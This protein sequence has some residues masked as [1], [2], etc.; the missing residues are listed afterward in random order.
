L[1]SKPKDLQTV[2]NPIRES[3]VNA[4]I[5]RPRMQ[6][7]SVEHGRGQG[8]LCHYSFR[9]L[10]EVPKAVVY[11]NQ[12]RSKGGVAFEPTDRLMD[13]GEQMRLVFTTTV[14]GSDRPVYFLAKGFFLRKS[15][16]IP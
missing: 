9:K 16:F 10:Q 7:E 14:E 3:E 2:F 1:F 4:E 12:T 15:F 8:L 6:T 5:V 11:M 13:P